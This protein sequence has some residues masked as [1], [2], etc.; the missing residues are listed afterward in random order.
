MDKTNLGRVAVEMQILDAYLD[1]LA[2]PRTGEKQRFDHQPTTAAC[3]VGSLDQELDFDTIETIDAAPA[4]CGWCEGKL[5]AHVLDD[6]LGLVIAEVMP[7]PQPRRLAN[8][9]GEASLGLRLRRMTAPFG[10]IRRTRQVCTIPTPHR[11]VRSTR[12][13]RKFGRRAARRDQRSGGT[14]SDQSGT[15]LLRHGQSLANTRSCTPCTMGSV[16]Q[17]WPERGERSC[18]GLDQVHRPACIV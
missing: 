3:S 13:L 9:R 18:I 14:R 17:V 11:K 1:K 16:H 8:D 15:K 4:S 7:T 12:S 2:D 10:S 6:V 5:A